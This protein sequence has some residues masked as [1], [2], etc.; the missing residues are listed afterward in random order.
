MAL[1]VDRLGRFLDREGVGSGPV[2][3]AR[4]EGGHSNETYLVRRDD[5]ALVLRRP[6]PPPLPPSAHDVLREAEVLRGLSGSGVP[7]PGVMAVCDDVAVLGAPFYLMEFL[8]GVILS[9]TTHPALEN[10]SVR[11]EIADLAVDALAALHAVD[12]ASR[13]E[14]ARLGRPDGYLERQL[15]RFADLWDRGRTR[16]LPELDEVTDWLARNRPDSGPT[17]VVHGDYRL[18]NLIYGLGRPVT[19]LGVLDWEMATLGDPLAD[20]GYLTAHWAERTT[21][22]TVMSDLQPVTREPGFPD[23][24]E[25]AARYAELTGRDVDDLAWYQVLALWKSAIFLEQSRKRFLSG[26]SSDP[27][28]AQTTEGV[29]GLVASARRRAWIGA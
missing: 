13:D 12:W 10:L 14:L 5:A 24:D 1:P 11:T 19:L 29:P 27:W 20:L 7:V 4:C 15:R 3:V 18:G 8:D 6:P 25:L 26:H 17:T 28:L 16:E 23:G 9:A 22:G 2:V 21:P